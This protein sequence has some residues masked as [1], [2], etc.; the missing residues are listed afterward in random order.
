MSSANIEY[1]GVVEGVVEE[2]VGRRA[3][4]NTSLEDSPHSSY[5]FRPGN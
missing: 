5:L 2:G 3:V 1:H 4:R